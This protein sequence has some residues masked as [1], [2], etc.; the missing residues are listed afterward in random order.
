MKKLLYSDSTLGKSQLDAV[1]CFEQKSSSTVRG[2][3]GDSP[4]AWGA[5][6]ARKIRGN[7]LVCSVKKL[8]RLKDGRISPQMSEK[9]TE[10]KGTRTGVTKPHIGEGSL[11]A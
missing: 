10:S 5:L 4:V 9:Q 7:L 2:S 1:P 3:L 6:S 8:R 11:L